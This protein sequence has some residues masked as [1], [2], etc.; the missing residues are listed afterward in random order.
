MVD[1]IDGSGKSSVIKIWQEQLLADGKK[2]FD[3][4]QH[5]K[6]TGTWPEAN[7]LMHYDYIFCGEPTYIGIG[8]VIR[9]ELIKNGTSYPPT[10]VAH[11]YSL[12]RL[13][14]YTNILVPLLQSGK[15]IIQDRGIST[16][17]AYQSISDNKLTLA[18]IGKMPGNAL[19]LKYRP[20]Y[21]ILAK[22][23]PEEAA[24]RLSGRTGKND[25]V[26]F[27]NLPF[28][29]TATKKFCSK[30]YQNYLKHYGTR[31]ISLNTASKFDIMKQEAILLLKKL[32]K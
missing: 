29:K 20:D 2:T 13:I 24:M 23:S 16:S 19:A 14:L 21:L 3:L 26:I 10:A 8:K 17:L 1:G 9:D 4:R 12:D 31:I 27:E 5:L 18:K 22:I 15:T 30:E 11:A 28:L 25:N 6:T 7:A 32:I